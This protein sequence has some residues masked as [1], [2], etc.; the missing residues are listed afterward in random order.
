[1]NQLG[2]K[3]FQRQQSKLNRVVGLGVLAASV[4]VGLGVGVLLSWAAWLP[5]S[6][7][8]A[9]AGF[10]AQWRWAKARWIKRFPEFAD[11]ETVWR[12]RSPPGYG[13]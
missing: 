8:L 3:E 11:P 7:L 12:Q 2:Y 4:G 1:V 10:E 6:A 5:V 13:A 9:L